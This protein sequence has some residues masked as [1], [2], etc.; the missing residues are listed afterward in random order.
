VGFSAYKKG[1]KR[2]LALNAF[3]LRTASGVL[4]ATPLTSRRLANA[5]RLWYLDDIKMRCLQR[6]NQ[7][8]KSFWPETFSYFRKPLSQQI[9][10]GK[11]FANWQKLA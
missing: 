9:K 7:Y 4:G 11:A 5:S 8:Q 3:F 1:I 10:A 6:Q 2:H